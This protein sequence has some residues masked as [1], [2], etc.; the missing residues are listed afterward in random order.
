MHNQCR[1]TPWSNKIGPLI[2]SVDVTIGAHQ[3]NLHGLACY[4]WA[5][6][7]WQCSQLSGIVLETSNT[8]RT[9]MELNE[10]QE[11]RIEAK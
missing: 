8:D 5:D 4:I 6:A 7:T 1:F 9:V 2:D 3:V 11:S 10:Y